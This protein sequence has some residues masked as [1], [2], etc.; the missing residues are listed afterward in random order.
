MDDDRPMTIGR[1]AELSGLSIHALRHYDDVGLLRPAEVDRGS[2]YR[3]YR[4]D[5]VRI[6]RLIR[7]LRWVDL[8]VDDVR[9][10]LEDLDGGRSRQ[11]L[12]RH[13]ERLQ[14]RKN[15]LDA[16]IS[17]VDRFLQEGLTM[18]TDRAG[19][20]PVQIKITVEDMAA[21]IAF[22]REAFGFRY[23]VTRRT[24]DEDHSSFVFGT[25]GQDGFFLIHLQADPGE[26][27][28]LG[29]STFGLLVD[30]L[31]TVHARAIGAGGTEVVAPCNP[32]GMPRASAIRDPS[33]NWV[34]LYQ[35]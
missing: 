22:Y 1:F 20:R 32:E 17:D 30:D 19:C 21:A 24:E 33:G 35:D 12:M 18:P 16:R 8:P 31:E 34:W 2:G 29:P 14:R 23:D 28:R 5:Q 4:R 10:V 15:H 26:V 3:R 27:D 13:R 6:A 25:Y 9:T 11:T 7:A